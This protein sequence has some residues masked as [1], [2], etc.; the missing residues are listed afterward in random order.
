MHLSHRCHPPLDAPSLPHTRHPFAALAPKDLT[1]GA[2]RQR[3]RA[4]YLDFPFLELQK[5]ETRR[6]RSLRGR[7][8]IPW[9]GPELA[10]T[11]ACRGE[12]LRRRLC[13]RFGTSTSCCFGTQDRAAVRL[14]R[15]SRS[16]CVGTQDRVGL[17]FTHAARPRHAPLASLP[18]SPRRPLSPPRAP[19]I[20]GA[21]PKRLDHRAHGATGA[22]RPIQ[23]FPFSICKVR[24]S[25]RSLARRP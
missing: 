7:D 21:C 4:P 25:A 22:V 18:S 9:T 8:I 15:Y 2:R 20:C 19:S 5:C 12:V 24:E 3:R 16:R 14:R 17:R 23:I 6:D 13:A 10:S 11:G 1:I